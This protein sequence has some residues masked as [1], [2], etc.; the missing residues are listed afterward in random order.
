MNGD[1]GRAD[2]E[3]KVSAF[4]NAIDDYNLAMRLLAILSADEDHV[5]PEL[6]VACR[7]SSHILL[8]AL[9]GFLGLAGGDAAPE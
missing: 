7:D 2:L 6:R 1:E 9:K 8:T 3:R 5:P 4:A